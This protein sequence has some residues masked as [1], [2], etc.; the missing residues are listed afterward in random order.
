MQ[1]R[2]CQLTYAVGRRE[3]CPSE[4]CANAASTN[5]LE[6]VLSAHPVHLPAGEEAVAAIA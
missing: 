5:A 3:R 2:H 1:S 6:V 4:A